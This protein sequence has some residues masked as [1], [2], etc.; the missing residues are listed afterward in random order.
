MARIAGFDRPI[1]HGLS[2]FGSAVRAVLRHMAG[3]DGASFRSA[4]ARFSRHVFPGE[5]LLTEIWK[6][7][8]EQIYFQCKVDERDEI[9][10][11]NATLT[12]A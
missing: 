2:T 3:D 11:A 5:T 9:V 6:A 4:S 10:L 8:D 7:S 12:L 1:L